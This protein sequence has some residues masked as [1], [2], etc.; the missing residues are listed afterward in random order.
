[1]TQTLEAL[2]RRFTIR[3]RML[4]A[5]GMVLCLFAL[6]GIAGFSGGAV[7]DRLADDFMHHSTRE[8]RETGAIRAHLAAL[9]LREKDMVIDYENGTEVLRH[10]EAWSR[11]IEDTRQALQALLAGEEDEDNA[12]ARKGLAALDA[13]EQA[14]VPVL[15]QIQVSAFDTAKAADRQLQRA[16][17]HVA[18]L[19][20]QV[21]RLSA[22]VDRE[23][24]AAQASFDA[25]MSATTFV[26]GG[27]LLLVAG[28]VV[29]LTLM[30]SRSILAPIEH[31]R[32]VAQA[33]AQ[34]Q[35]GTP[36]DARGRDEAA[37][38]LA[39]LD[40]MQR[41]LASLVGDVRL[42]A[43]SIGTASDEVAAGNADLSTRTEQAASR[44]QQT[45][46]SM[47]QITGTVRQSSDA[48]AQAD[49]LARSAAGIAR[50]GG[51]VVGQ[52]VSTMD[53][54]HASARRIADIIGTIDGIAFQTNILALNA[55][56]EA[57][58]AGEQGRGFAV[59]AGEVRALAQRSAAAAREIKT[60]IGTSVERVEAGNR[61]VGEAGSTMAEIVASVQR[62]SDIIGEISAAAAEQ[63]NG[64]G[65]VNGAVTDLDRM[66]QQNAALVE[67][68][69]AA[70]ESLKDQARRLSQA[71]SA[72]QTAA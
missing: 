55:A 59:V 53:Q 35:L 29:P 56:V 20:E 2:L 64:I 40:H 6:V 32:R 43:D 46:S 7:L 63:S 3:V 15:S 28:V 47:E 70:A 69:A 54:I 31:A 23:I 8:L 19:E 68:S 17:E 66:T 25:T 30:N 4:G 1:M 21:D 57:A 26:F 42:S 49:Q 34:G 45:A 48:A 71:V 11:S 51:D 5:I 41:S 16:H 12:Y 22:I 24:D 61:L 37:E 10:R 38:L 44:L 13:Y 62:V 72:F 9:R 33:V 18:V 50:R 14:S 36:I 58:R 67:E 65:L 27:V 52:V 39:A 60:L